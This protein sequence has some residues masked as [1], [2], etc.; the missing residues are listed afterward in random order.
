MVYDGWIVRYSGGHTKRANCVNGIHPSKLPL[1]EKVRFCEEFYGIRRM[2]PLF[3]LTSFSD[4]D[5]LDKFLDGRGYAGFDTTLVMT[6]ALTADTGM[7]SPESPV[8]WVEQNQWMKAFGALSRLNSGEIRIRERII[9]RITGAALFG[10][11]ESGGEVL[12]CGFGV[13]EGPFL[14]LF[15]FVTHPAR[16]RKGYAGQLLKALIARGRSLGLET[17]YLQVEEVNTAAVKLYRK[18]GFRELY[19]YWYREKRGEEGV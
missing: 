5:G 2:N 7:V 8:R 16:R 13:L 4:P 12:A 11:L 15:S 17:A 6:R 19:R 14:G 3:R 18:F 1:I 9:G 10:C